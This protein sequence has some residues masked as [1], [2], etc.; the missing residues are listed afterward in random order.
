MKIL[1]A[2]GEGLLAPTCIVFLA[3]WGHEVEV[4]HDGREALRRARSWAPD[5][6]VARVA[7]DG[8]DGYALTAAVRADARLRDTAVV[9]AAPAGDRL[10][11]ERARLLGASGFLGTPLSVPELQ[12]TI[13]ALA[14]RHVH[15]GVARPRRRGVA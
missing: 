4:V 12:R 6:L 14:R 1:V 9:L 7:L 10:S 8:M 15:E 11:R 3:Y 13:G 5:V 2:D